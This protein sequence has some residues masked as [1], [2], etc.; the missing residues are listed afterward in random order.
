MNREPFIAAIMAFGLISGFFNPIMIALA[1][2]LAD[3]FASSLLIVRLSGLSA[4][5]TIIFAATMTVMLAGIPAALFER[6]TGRAETDQ[7]SLFIWLAC[8]TLIALPAVIRAIGLLA[9]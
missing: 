5:F 2:P 9:G 3:L 6:V 1:K 7:A 8:T 4:F